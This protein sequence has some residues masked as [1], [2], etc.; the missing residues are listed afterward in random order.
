M[1][2]GSS[3]HSSGDMDLKALG[4]CGDSGFAWLRTQQSVRSAAAKRVS[5]MNRRNEQKTKNTASRHARR[6]EIPGRYPGRNT[7][8]VGGTVILYGKDCQMTHQTALSD[9]PALLS[10]I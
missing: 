3:T 2:A 9:D 5:M 1:A 7:G 4:R 10:C 6:E 8:K